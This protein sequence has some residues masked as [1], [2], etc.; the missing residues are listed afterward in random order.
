MVHEPDTLLVLAAAYDTLEEAEADYEAVKALYREVAASHDFDAAVVQRGDDGKV[1]V[2]RKH[3]QPTRHG[4]AKGLGW[5]LAV[6]AAF[7]VFPAIGLAGGLLAGGGTGAM[8]GAVKGH[9]QGGLDDDE[10]RRIGETLEQG[11]AG[12]LA[13]YATNLADQVAATV[14]AQSRYV[15]REIEARGEDLARQVEAAQA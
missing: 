6:G 13:V 12:L 1:H 3:E 2:V 11:Q 14:R 7:A 9:M 4:A 5:G 10:L 15:S 8:I